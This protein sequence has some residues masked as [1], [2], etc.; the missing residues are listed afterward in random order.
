MVRYFGRYANAA[1]GKRRA[2]ARAST[3][4]PEH[5]NGA[6]TPVLCPLE[7]PPYRRR[8][9]LTWAALVRKI[10]EADPLLCPYCGAE[11]KIIGDQDVVGS[12]VQ[13][14]D[15]TSNPV[16]NGYPVAL[17]AENVL[18]DVELIRIVVDDENAQDVR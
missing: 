1:R 3:D 11:M 18:D 17:L 4:D 5:P 6:R 14:F 7:E 9:R 15:G 12:P 16:R 2:A 13:E 10:Y 8:T